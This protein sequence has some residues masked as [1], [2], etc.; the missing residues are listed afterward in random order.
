MP[1][2]QDFRWAAVYKNNAHLLSI[3]VFYT[4]KFF[5][6]IFS[7]GGI[8]MYTKSYENISKLAILIGLLIKLK[9][10]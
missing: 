10:N 6:K 5:A 8:L 9:A 2:K 3:G 7:I 1:V 4:N